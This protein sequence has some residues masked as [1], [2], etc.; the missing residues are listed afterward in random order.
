VIGI[1]GIGHLAIKFSVAM[2][3]E[4]VAISRS[5]EKKQLCLDLGASDHVNI[6]ENKQLSKYYKYF[7]YILCTVDKPTEWEKIFNMV[8]VGG[9]II[10]LGI[11]KLGELNIPMSSTIYERI[12]VSGSNIG[13]PSKIR[14]MLLFAREHDITPDVQVYPVSQ[15]NQAW[16]DF[17]EGKPRFR[18]V[19][20]IED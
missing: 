13:S 7:D 12:L 6:N 2:N 20:K 5:E 9:H 11:P 3:N 14:E 8:D 16:T 18:Y 15:I 1:G 19:I 17:R 4:V 10:L